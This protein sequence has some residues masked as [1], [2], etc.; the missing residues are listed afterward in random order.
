[1]RLILNCAILVLQKTATVEPVIGIWSGG[2]GGEM[3]EIQHMISHACPNGTIQLLM[4]VY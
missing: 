4:Y 2:G 1:M 3:G